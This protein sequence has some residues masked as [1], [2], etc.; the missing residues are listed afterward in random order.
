MS[1]PSFLTL[2]LARAQQEERLRVSEER[3]RSS[4]LLAAGPSKRRFPSLTGARRLRDWRIGG[5]GRR[6]APAGGGA[7]VLMIRLACPDDQ[8]GLL[9]LAALDS[10]E[11]ISGPALVVVADGEIVAALPLGGGAPIADPFRQTSA[12]VE[13][14]RLRAR[15][16]SSEGDRFAISAVRS[17][18]PALAI[19]AR[20]P[21][22]AKCSS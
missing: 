5:R 9:R 3:S 21:V 18:R 2:A 10:A 15:Q 6:A 8:P 4:E 19:S 20:P 14:L 12:I 13:V 22:H 7:D 16:L 17:S 11:P 1:Q